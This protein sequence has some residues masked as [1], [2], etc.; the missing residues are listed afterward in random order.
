MWRKQPY[1]INNF[2]IATVVQLATSNCLQSNSP[3]QWYFDRI[4]NL[5][6]HTLYSTQCL[7][8][9]VSPVL[10]L[11]TPLL[12][13]VVTQ[14][15]R[16][17]TGFSQ[18]IAWGSAGHN[19][20]LSVQTTSRRRCFTGSISNNT[21]PLPSLASCLRLIFQQLHLQSYFAVSLGLSKLQLVM[22]QFK[23]QPTWTNIDINIIWLWVY[24]ARTITIRITILYIH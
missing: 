21:L 22:K 10:L 18:N 6:I 16:Q 20:A 23:I 19:T 1:K 9:W 14:S 2:N 3:F 15:G 24:T 8:S 12:V 5:I 17:R 4:Q 11:A 13:I 7:A